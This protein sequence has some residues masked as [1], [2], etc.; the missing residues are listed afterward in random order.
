[1]Y[2]ASSRKLD[3]IAHFQSTA[4]AARSIS[5]LGLDIALLAADPTNESVERLAA[6]TRVER[7]RVARKV[8]PPNLNIDAQRELCADP[9]HTAEM[10]TIARQYWGQ[11]RNGDPNWPANT[12]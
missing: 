9:A 11:K 8:V 3:R 6:F 7:Y 12:I 2:L 5:E 1:L 10:E 4:S